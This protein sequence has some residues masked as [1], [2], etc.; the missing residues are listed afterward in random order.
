MTKKEF[1]GVMEVWVNGEEKPRSIYVRTMGR[2]VFLSEGLQ[3]F[4]VHP[5]N[6]SDEEHWAR[7][8][9]IVKGVTITKHKMTYP[10]YEKR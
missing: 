9:S 8:Y 1:V 2:E 10:Q 7:E 4:I 3:E 6:T 5:S